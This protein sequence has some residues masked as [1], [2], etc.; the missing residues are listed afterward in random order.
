MADIKDANKEER[1]YCGFQIPPFA[2][3]RRISK[4]IVLCRVPPVSACL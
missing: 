1:V 4:H 2:S 3:E